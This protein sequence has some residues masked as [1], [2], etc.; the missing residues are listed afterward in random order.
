MGR[1]IPGIHRLHNLQDAHLTDHFA[2]SIDID[3]ESKRISSK[4]LVSDLGLV[5]RQDS[6]QLVHTLRQ[7]GGHYSKQYHRDHELVCLI[8]VSPYPMQ[9]VLH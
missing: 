4:P 6:D 7:S 2:H 3:N 1:H 5:S 9:S 8:E